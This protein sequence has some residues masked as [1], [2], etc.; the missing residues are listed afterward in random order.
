[1]L[2]LSL[3]PSSPDPRLDKISAH[4]HELTFRMNE[5]I[6]TTSPGSLPNTA[7]QGFLSS[8][9]DEINLYLTKGYAPQV[10]ETTLVK[11]TNDLPMASDCELVSVLSF[12]GPQCCH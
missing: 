7:F 5:S 12:T 1:M 2:P 11:V 3:T 9:L 4:R 8:V 6:P 10:F